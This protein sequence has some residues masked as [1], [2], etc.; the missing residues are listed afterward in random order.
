MQC[1]LGCQ[2]ERA[3]A[4]GPAAPQELFGTDPSFERFEAEVVSGVSRVN[5]NQ[6][7]AGASLPL[8]LTPFFIS[9]PISSLFPSSLLSLPSSLFPL[10]SLPSALSSLTSSLPAF[11]WLYAAWLC[12]LL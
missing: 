1:I 6:A 7:G 9:P 5:Y 12:V 10:L 8:L 11:L 4:L 3:A 2:E